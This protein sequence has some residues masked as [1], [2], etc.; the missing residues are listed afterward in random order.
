MVLAMI[1][2]L[3]GLA[4]TGWLYTTDRF[5]GDETVERIHLALAWTIVVL[6][7]LHVAGVMVASVR[8]RENLVVA[9]ATGDKREAR[10]SDIE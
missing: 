6:A 1:A 4:L 8:H 3:S 10:G 2:C 5:W 9:M 7:V